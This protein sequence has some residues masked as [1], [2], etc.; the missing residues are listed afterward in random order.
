MTAVAVPL[1]H[2][3]ITYVVVHTGGVQSPLLTLYFVQVLATAMLVDTLVA[4]GSA[5]WAIVLWVTAVGWQPGGLVTVAPLLSS[6]A[7]VSATVYHGIWAAFLLYCLALLV[8]LGGY[9]SE[10]LRSSE[11]D[12]EQ[13]NRRL[14]E[15]L[16]SL[17]TAYERLQRAEVQLIQSEKMRGLGQLVA[18]IAHELNNPISFVSGNVEHLRDYMNRLRQALDAYAGASLSA[19]ERLR[20]DG[21]RR[22]LHIDEALA[23]L[24]GLV[25]DVEEGARRTRNIVNELR[26]FSHIDADDRWRA[27]W[28]S[29]RFGDEPSRESGNDDDSIGPRG[30][31]CED[32]RG[33]DDENE[34]NHAPTRAHGSGDAHGDIEDL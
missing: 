27:E 24:P 31:G 6:G 26:A 17:G 12:L 33:K 25:D 5:V 10:R 34:Q 3:F 14:Q 20:L 18:G 8:Y 1:D 30:I 15:A 23:D 13:R 29:S 16:S 4:A 7:A 19:A 32:E 2:V 11:R 9:I 21:L 28:R 22:D